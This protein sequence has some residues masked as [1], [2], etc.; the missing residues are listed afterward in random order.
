MFTNIVRAL[1]T[2]GASAALSTAATAQYSQYQPYPGQPQYPAQYTSPAQGYAPS[3]A[4]YPANPAPAAPASWSYNPYTSG[5]TSCPQRGIGDTSCAER[6]KPTAGQPNY[7]LYC[8]VAAGM[9]AIQADAQCQQMAARQA[10]DNAYAPV[11]QQVMQLAAT[12]AGTLPLPAS[13]YE[14]VS[15][16]YTTPS[17]NRRRRVTVKRLSSYSEPATKRVCDTFT[18]ID[19][20][21]DGGTSTTATARR[22]KGGDGQWHET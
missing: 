3:I 22:C 11:A 10:Y 21:L 4:T 1:V 15:V 8:P 14:P 13:A 19:A 16:D 7:H 18:K 5:L 17:D 2:L 9:P 20:D 6:I 12:Q